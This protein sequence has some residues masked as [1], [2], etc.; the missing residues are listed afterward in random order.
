MTKAIVEPEDIEIPNR[1][2]NID[3]IAPVTETN[4]VGMWD[5]PD[6]LVR[7][8]FREYR[9]PFDQSGMDYHELEVV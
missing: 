7:E 3:E 1:F 8:E 2:A 9:D 5:D 4:R 6:D